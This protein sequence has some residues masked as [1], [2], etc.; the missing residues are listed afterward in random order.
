MALLSDIAGKA[1]RPYLQKIMPP[2][3]P[4]PRSI[5]S[6]LTSPISQLPEELKRLRWFELR[7]DRLFQEINQ[8]PTFMAMIDACD[9]VLDVPIAFIPFKELRNNDTFWSGASGIYSPEENVVG[10]DYEETAFDYMFNCPSY[11]HGRII[12][13]ELR[14]AYH[15][16][17]PR[18]SL[19][20]FRTDPQYLFE[21]TF[22]QE[23]EVKAFEATV[24]WE[25]RKLGYPD[26]WHSFVSSSPDIADAF[27]NA[28]KEDRYAV[29][30]GK[31]QTAAFNQWSQNFVRV[32]FYAQETISE[33]RL[34]MTNNLADMFR[35]S[36]PCVSKNDK[37]DLKKAIVPRVMSKDLPPSTHEDRRDESGGLMPYI[38]SS[39]TV[40]ARPSYLDES[41]SPY[42]YSHTV[43]GALWHELIK[44]LQQFNVDYARSK[45][46]KDRTLDL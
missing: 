31:A 2:A 44:A 25:L 29:N 35:R 10:V 37:G 34:M 4:L 46:N 14:H 11:N 32:N 40:V 45:A 23:A 26:Y 30:N 13:H 33:L 8:S 15:N 24:C 19:H 7:L 41:K 6:W 9:G 5:R 20:R 1:F 36:D 3:K 12:I 17:E 16:L 38:D 18:I 22:A 28:I 27:L 43:R 39:G 21:K 42:Y